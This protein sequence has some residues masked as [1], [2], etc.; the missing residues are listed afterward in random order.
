MSIRCDICGEWSPGTGVGHRDICLWCYERNF[1][2]NPLEAPTAR[3]A[4]EVYVHGA[5]PLTPCQMDA[6]R[7]LAARWRQEEDAP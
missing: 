7:R 6:L 3:E 1:S 4:L 5:P 2:G